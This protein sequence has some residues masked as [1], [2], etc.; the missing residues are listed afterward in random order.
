MQERVRARGVQDA[1]EFLGM[2]RHEEIPATIER[3]DIAVSPRSVF[4]QSPM[5]ILEYMAMGKAVLAPDTKNI[6]DLIGPDREGVVFR[7]DDPDSLRAALRRLIHDPGLRERLGAAARR[8]VERRHTWL[9]N[10]RRV[11]QL[12][13]H[14]RAGEGPG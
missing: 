11:L 7:P 10:A 12:F 9:G 5:K 2:A 8:R 14:L 4:Y 13:D 6:H 3:F 1:V